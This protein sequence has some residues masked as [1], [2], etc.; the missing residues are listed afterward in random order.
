MA[1]VPSPVAPGVAGPASESASGSA[2]TISNLS[3]SPAVVDFGQPTGL[4][5]R[6]VGGTPPYTFSYSGLPV[7][8][9]SQDTS[10]LGCIPL[11]SGSFTV[12]ETVRDGTGA[13][14]QATADLQVNPPLNVSIVSNLTIGRAPFTVAFSSSVAGGTEPRSYLWNFDDGTTSTSHNP[15][16]TFVGAGVYYVTLGISDASSAFRTAAVNVSSTPSPGNPYEMTANVSPA[17]C[18]PVIIGGTHAADGSPL[19]FTPGLY[20]LRAPPCLG[21]DFLAWSVTPPD[22]TTN[23]SQPYALLEVQGPANLTAT[24]VPVGANLSVANTTVPKGLALSQGVKEA[25]GG[26]AALAAI[27]VLFYLGR[28]PPRAPAPAPASPVAPV[29]GRPY[30]S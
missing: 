3:W 10:T 21:Y 30:L 25:L 14:G 28:R 24:Y 11:A 13:S 6:A 26:T 20:R 9:P 15:T 17:T 7:G 18:G 22:R 2:I 27:G 19:V 4:S 8:C 29:P 5:G 1:P 23:G 16:H 12:M